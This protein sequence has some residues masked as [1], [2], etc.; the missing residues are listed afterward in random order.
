MAV[1]VQETS[2]GN[3]IQVKAKRSMGARWGNC[4]WLA[5]LGESD[6]GAGEMRKLSSLAL[7]E[8]PTSLILSFDGKTPRDQDTCQLAADILLASENF[9]NLLAR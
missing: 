3:P 6:L 8:N 9:W 5:G 7:R 4:S 1:H 2:E